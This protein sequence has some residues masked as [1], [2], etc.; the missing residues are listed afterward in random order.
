M[1][2][3]GAQCTCTYLINAHMHV[4]GACTHSDQYSQTCHTHTW[5]H[6]HTLWHA[7]TWLYMHA[8][9]QT[10]THLNDFLKHKILLVQANYW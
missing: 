4:K 7:C 2:H 3:T 8:H 10:H 9:T 1:I 5:M 6:T